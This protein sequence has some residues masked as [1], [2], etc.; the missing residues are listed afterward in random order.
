MPQRP[1][2]QLALGEVFCERRE[3]LEMSQEDVA[4]AAGSSQGR[5][6]EIE[7]GDNPSFGLALRIARALGWSPGELMRRVEER[8]LAKGSEGEA[9]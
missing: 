2:P 5:I 3:E 1:D 4:L 9:A 6:S 8:E 7:A